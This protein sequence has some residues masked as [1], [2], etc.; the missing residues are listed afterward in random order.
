MSL[1]LDWMDRLWLRGFAG[2]PQEKP[3]VWLDH[4]LQHCLPVSHRGGGS[5]GGGGL[6]RT[7]WPLYHPLEVHAGD[8]F[9]SLHLI[10]KITDRVLSKINFSC[11]ARLDFPDTLPPAHYWCS[12]TTSLAPHPAHSCLSPVSRP[13]LD[14]GEPGPPRHHWD[15]QTPWSAPDGR[16]ESERMCTKGLIIFIFG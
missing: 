11:L 14:S 6:G 4:C 7:R 9:L 2:E 8:L 13:S 5:P 12:S 3:Y 15:V 16:R 10:P 1:P